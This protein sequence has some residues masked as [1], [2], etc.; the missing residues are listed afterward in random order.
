L[1][2][3]V[4]GNGMK[5]IWDYPMGRGEFLR[6]G[7]AAAGCLL[8]GNAALPGGSAAD[9]RVEKKPGSPG[10]P[11]GV[12]IYSVEKRGYVV[13]DRVV[14]SDAE[15]R[16]VL[17]PEQ[18]QVTRRKGTERAFSGKYWNEHATGVYRCVCCGNDLFS[19][20]TKYESGTG[21]PSFYA[22]V[23]PENVRTEEDN[24][25]FSRRTEVL[26]TR[27]DSH[28]GHVFP[29]GPKPT[30]LRYCMNSASLDFVPSNPPGVPGKG[31]KS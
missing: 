29:D 24:S 28:L 19:S 8:L 1:D 21:W 14:K 2:G 13:A 22:P 4:E 23:A 31:K 26:C 27:C 25:F 10:D 16:K 3:S 6:C 18:Y 7:L 11:R 20:E 17:T 5:T 15:W 9:P 12:K 30:G